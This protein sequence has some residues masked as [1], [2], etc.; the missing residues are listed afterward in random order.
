MGPKPRCARVDRLVSRGTDVGRG[1]AK[2]SK[3][4]QVLGPVTAPVVGEDGMYEGV[5]GHALQ[6][7][8]VSV[9]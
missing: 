6:S 3:W 4:G 8:D 5:G 9:Q 2:V 1:T 7:E